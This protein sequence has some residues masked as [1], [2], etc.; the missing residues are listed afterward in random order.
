MTAYVCSGLESNTQREC[1]SVRA[2]CDALYP[3]SS[4]LEKLEVRMLRLLR[5][6]NIHRFRPQ[7]QQLMNFTRLVDIK[8]IEK[9]WDY[10]E[11]GMHS[12]L[13]SK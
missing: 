12:L 10:I 4:I 5:M 11:N 9:H 7:N 6:K 8:D 3:N 13:N 1:I 2:L